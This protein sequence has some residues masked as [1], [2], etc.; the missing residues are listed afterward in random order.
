MAPVEYAGAIPILWGY[1]MPMEAIAIFVT[2]IAAVIAAFVGV[3][4]QRR[5][6]RQQIT[7][8][9]IVQ[10]E[11]DNDM[12]EARENFIEFTTIP[13]KMSELAHPA[14]ISSKEAQYV[15]R[16]INNWENISIGI[17]LNIIDFELIKRYNKSAIINHWDSASQ[18]V[19]ELRK[20]TGNRFYYHEF[21]ELARWM[22]DDKMPH[23]VRGDHFWVRHRWLIGV[24]VAVVSFILGAL[25]F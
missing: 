13:G 14:T 10:V 7:F 22:R 19:S 24:V 11:S 2:G 15:T 21:E 25:M 3:T 17:Q 23:R 18:F 5:V 9:H 6:V 8:E 20:T 1:A 16:F 4:D 12:I